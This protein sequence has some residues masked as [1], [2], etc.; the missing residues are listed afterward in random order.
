MARPFQSGD[1]GTTSWEYPA[2]GLRGGGCSALASRV[3]RRILIDHARKGRTLK[4]GGPVRVIPLEDVDE[5]AFHQPQMLLDLHEALSRLQEIDPLQSSIIEYRFFGGLTV[6]EI[7]EVV[8]C[9]SAT[10]ERRW[11]IARAWLYRELSSPTV[12]GR[13]QSP[14]TG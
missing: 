4:R 5:L 2:A 10:V 8:G 9:S 13:E 1:G 12:N 3:V 7:A 14:K 6:D 11:R